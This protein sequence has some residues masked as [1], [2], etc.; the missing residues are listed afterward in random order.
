MLLN[1]MKD[2]TKQWKNEGRSFTPGNFFPYYLSRSTYL[3]QR[4]PGRK[5]ENPA[6]SA[7][8]G[9]D[10]RTVQT[11]HQE[12]PYTIPRD[13]APGP[14]RTPRHLPG[15]LFLSMI[16]DKPSTPP[17]IPAARL[18][19]G[20]PDTCQKSTEDWSCQR[21]I[22]DKPEKHKTKPR[23]KPGENPAALSARTVVY[24]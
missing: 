17:D 16:I 10:H 11:V 22:P 21:S 14:A 13:P 24:T 1:E 20:N 12:L 19:P 15:I 2:T 3:I 9:L 18:L 8:I 4:T 23:K 5:P 7:M 6:P